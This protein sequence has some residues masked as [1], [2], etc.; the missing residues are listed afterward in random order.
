MRKHNR[1]RKPLG[2]W[3]RL[4]EES[5]FPAPVDLQYT[6]GENIDVVK[7]RKGD[8]YV[9]DIGGNKYRLIT[10][11]TFQWQSVL[12]DIMLTHAEYDEWSKKV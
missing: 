9:F 4:I 3:R 7:K 8:Y 5:N 1:S 6:F 12:I 2:T 11:I 10:Q